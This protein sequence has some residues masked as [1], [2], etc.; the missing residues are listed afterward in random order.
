MNKNRVHNNTSRFFVD[1]ICLAEMSKLVWAAIDYHYILVLIYDVCITEGENYRYAVLYQIWIFTGIFHRRRWLQRNYLLQT[2]ILHSKICTGKI[3][4]LS[5]CTRR[6]TWMQLLGR[7][8]KSIYLWLQIKCK[9][10]LPKRSWRRS[11][12]KLRHVKRIF[13]ASWSYVNFVRMIWYTFVIML[14]LSRGMGVGRI[15]DHSEPFH[16]QRTKR[17]LF[18]YYVVLHKIKS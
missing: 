18:S 8:C 10:M 17:S 4:C 13:L 9:Y 11:Q 14:V 5:K 6:G 3:K 2:S 15:F 1:G 12:W 7:L 16:S